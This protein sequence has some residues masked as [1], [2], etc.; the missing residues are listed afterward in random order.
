MS[1]MLCSTNSTIVLFVTEL[2]WILTCSLLELMHH[3]SVCVC[4]GGGRVGGGVHV[5]V[6]VFK[7]FN[8]ISISVVIKCCFKRYS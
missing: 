1:I 2:G 5:C 3:R 7:N 6:C 4:V 8:S